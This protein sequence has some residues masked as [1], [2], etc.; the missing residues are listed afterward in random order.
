MNAKKPRRRSLVT[1]DDARVDH[2][3]ITLLTRVS[4]LG[5]QVRSLS[6]RIDDPRYR[7]HPKRDAAIRL[8]REL[9]R[10][11]RAM[12]PM[13]AETWRGY[14]MPRRKQLVERGTFRWPDPQMTSMEAA[15]W[16]AA[17]W[18]EQ[19]GLEDEQT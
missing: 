18:T 17:D 7:D 15:A 6:L 19:F 16:F 8:R 2:A 10:Q 3:L 1:H 12:A 5:N 11:I 9:T 13:A 14:T 4:E